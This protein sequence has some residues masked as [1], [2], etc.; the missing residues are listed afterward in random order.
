MRDAHPEVGA[1]FAHD[2]APRAMAAYFRSGGTDQPSGTVMKYTVAG[3]EY[4]VLANARGI[5][6]VYRVKPDGYLKGL[7][8]WP[9]VIDQV[10]TG[11]DEP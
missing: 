5:L 8:R 9:A 3:K 1:D 7:R 11:E 2:Y 6:A 10:V 4:V